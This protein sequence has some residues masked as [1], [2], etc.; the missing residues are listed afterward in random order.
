MTDLTMRPDT[1]LPDAASGGPRRQ[2]EEVRK[3]AELH[4]RLID[5]VEGHDKIA[6]KAEPDFVAV[7]EE[8]RD[9]HRDQAGRVASMLAGLGH[10][11]GRDGSIFGSVNRAVVEMRSWFDDIGPNVLEAVRQGEKHVHDAFEE[12]IAASPSVSR[13]AALDAM[14]Q[15]LAQLVERHA[16]QQG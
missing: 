14:R 12:A 9:L 8:F 13:R 3:L 6:E 4:T 15:E 16:P 1:L 2:E 10:D 5:T 7:A 11:P